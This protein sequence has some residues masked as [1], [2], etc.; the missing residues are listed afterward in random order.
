MDFRASCANCLVSAALLRATFRAISTI[1]VLLAWM[2]ALFEVNTLVR[3]ATSGSTLEA[4]VA[5]VIC[6]LHALKANIGVSASEGAAA[7]G[8][9][10]AVRVL[11]AVK[12]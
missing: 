9:L 7:E 4:V 1:T 3:K 10:D 5:H 8:V 2:S 11:R 6:R 12:T